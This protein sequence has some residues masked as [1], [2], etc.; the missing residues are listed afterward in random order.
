MN[1][2]P[3]SIANFTEKSPDES[4]RPSGNSINPLSRMELTAPQKLIQNTPQKRQPNQSLPVV[5]SEIS[6]SSPTKRIK[7]DPS[8]FRTLPLKYE[9]CPMKDL[10]I[11]ISSMIQ[12]LISTNDNLPPR[13]NTLTRFHSRTPPGISVFE[14]LQRLAKH[15]TLTPP[16]LLSMVYY[17]DQLCL[18]YPDFIINSLTVHRFLITACTVA[19][20]GLSDAFLNN[21]MYARVGGINFSELGLLELDFLYRLDWKIIPNSKSLANY[22]RGLVARS[23]N[24]KIEDENFPVKN[25]INHIETKDLKNSKTGQ[26]GNHRNES[27]IKTPKNIVSKNQ[28]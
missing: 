7:Q 19:S 23:G 5:P 4:E 8:L 20:K 1:C 6:C 15:T 18:L 14:Y 10:V 17:I 27:Q 9:L 22:Y 12:E 26:D 21:A 11:L 3:T 13:S 24:Y 16:L 2:S 25:N 28:E